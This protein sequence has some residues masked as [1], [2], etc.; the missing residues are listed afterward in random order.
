MQL[1]MEERFKICDES[2]EKLLNWIADVEQK[3]TGQEPAKEDA[4]RLRNQINNLKVICIR[5]IFWR[6]CFNIYTLL[7]ANR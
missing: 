1:A 5:L 7:S 4:N 3:L 6:M 2:I